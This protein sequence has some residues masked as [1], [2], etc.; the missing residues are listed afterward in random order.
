MKL[1][2][3]EFIRRFLLHTLPDGFHR[4][5]HFG[6]MAN[7]HR[8]AKRALCR[9]IL[10]PERTAPNIAEPSPVDSAPHTWSRF[11]PVPIVVAPCA[12][13]SAFDTA[14]AAPTLEHHRSDVTHREPAHALHDDHHS[15]FRFHRL[16]H[17]GRCRIR[18]ATQRNDNHSVQPI[19]DR[20][21]LQNALCLKLPPMCKQ[22]VSASGTQSADSNLRSRTIPIAAPPCIPS[23][24]FVQSGFNE[25]AS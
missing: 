12:S 11:L 23:R 8:A 20:D 15:P 3:G 7:R 19:I 2:P 13:S 1:K 22:Y 4:I 5:R 24:A 17:R 25:V 18:A 14:S 16:D 9:S 21:R 6:F 10:D